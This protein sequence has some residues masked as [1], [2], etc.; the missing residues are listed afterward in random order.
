M[1]NFSRFDLVDYWNN[2]A[3]NKFLNKLKKMNFFKF[4]RGRDPFP[5]FFLFREKG[6][7]LQ[8]NKKEVLCMEFDLFFL[9]DRL[10]ISRK[11]SI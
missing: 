7:R 6:P 10:K 1:K 9:V 8:I 3:K 11:P 4:V 5:F 2:Q